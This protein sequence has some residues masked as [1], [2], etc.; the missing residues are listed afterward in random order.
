[1]FNGNI[2]CML[3][4]DKDLQSFLTLYQNIDSL[5]NTQVGRIE[6]QT[7]ESDSGWCQR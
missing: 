7:L 2:F 5:T 6:Y 3:H 4:S 1:M